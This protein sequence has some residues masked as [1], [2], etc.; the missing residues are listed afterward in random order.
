M[1]E[2]SF[3]QLLSALENKKELDVGAILEQAQKVGLAI[4][5]PKWILDSGYVRPHEGR[6]EIITDPDD[7]ECALQQNGIDLRLDEVYVADGATQFSL[8]KKRDHRCRYL[9]LEPSAEN[10]FLF[11]PGK[12]YA[13]DFFEAVEIPEGTAAYL[14][15]RSSINRYSGI[16]LSGLYDSGFRGRIG[17]IFRPYLPTTIER[18]CRMAQI[19]F[20]KADSYRTYDG[21]YQDQKAQV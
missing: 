14:F 16:F 5:N 12:Q 4:V 3:S 17:G 15:V 8:H 7:G 13:W 10:D 1:T 21:Q 20:F 19:V 9:K 11:F 18:G 2:G 6:P